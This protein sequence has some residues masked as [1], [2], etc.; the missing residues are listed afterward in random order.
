MYPIY[1]KYP[2]YRESSRYANSSYAISIYATFQKVLQK[3]NLCEFHVNTGG[4]LDMRIRVM[5]IVF[6][7]LPFDSL[8]AIFYL[9]EFSQ[10]PKCAY[11]EEP[12]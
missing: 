7:R 8:C 10:E 12:L 4:S 6:M 11:L 2:I 3:F 1:P 5:R 9:C